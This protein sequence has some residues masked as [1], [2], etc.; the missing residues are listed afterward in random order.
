[1]EADSTALMAKN[2]RR[3]EHCWFLN[4]QSK[5][6]I[7]NA[8]I[9]HPDEYSD[10]DAVG[11]PSPMAASQEIYPTAAMNGSDRSEVIRQLNGFLR[12]EISAAETYRMAIDQI[13][14]V[15]KTA[16]G[17][18]GR[19]REIQ[20]EHGRAAQSLRSRIRELGGEASYS[21]GTWGAW[22]RITMGAAK[23]F[24]DAATLKALSEGETRGLQ[25]FRA[26]LAYLD[27]SSAELVRNQLIPAQE[28]HIR[29]LE[30]WIA[31]LQGH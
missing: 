27:V 9:S 10:F 21:S 16:D 7:M 25:M 4:S 15:E 28:R 5:G 29:V 24:G 1:M 22:V 6:V 17:N 18:V 23:L 26:G 19:L 8:D 3:Y 30:Q 12:G 20:E 13:P 31:A 2:R 14:R 11:I